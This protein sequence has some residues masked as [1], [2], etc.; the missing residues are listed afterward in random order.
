MTRD[1]F[2]TRIT[3]AILVGQR[4]SGPADLEGTMKGLDPFDQNY[5]PNYDPTRPNEALR[6]SILPLRGIAGTLYLPT[7]LQ[8]GQTRQNGLRLP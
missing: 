7:F 8:R 2:I 3:V 5:D 4:K 1:D 6:D